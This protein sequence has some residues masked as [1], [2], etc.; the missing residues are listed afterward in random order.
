MVHNQVAIV[1]GVYYPSQVRITYVD[2]TQVMKPLLKEFATL[3]KLFW[4]FQIL[5]VRIS[6]VPEH[7]VNRMVKKLRL[8]VLFYERVLV[9]TPAAK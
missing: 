5:N 9:H 4:L 2:K 7:K 1:T 3:L 6:P 8:W